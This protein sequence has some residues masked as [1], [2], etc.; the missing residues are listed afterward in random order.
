[1]NR[2]VITKRHNDEGRYDYV[3]IPGCL[4]GEML[5]R[6]QH[7]LDWQKALSTEIGKHIRL[8]DISE[9]E[10]FSGGGAL[11]SLRRYHD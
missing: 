2:A 3:P 9:A 5:D 6:T 7:L 4:I 10:L 1:M 8:R 11:P